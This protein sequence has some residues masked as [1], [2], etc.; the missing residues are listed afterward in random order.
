M[1]CDAC[2][3]SRALVTWWHDQLDK[4]LELCG[5]H[6]DQHALALV[7]KGWAVLTDERTPDAPSLGP[8]TAD[9][10]TH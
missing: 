1:P 9:P 6:S 2:H 5:H 3:I 10:A 4:E 7:D 8:V